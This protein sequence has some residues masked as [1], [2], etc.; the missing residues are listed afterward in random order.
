MEKWDSM[1]QFIQ[2]KDRHNKQC[3]SENYVC[4]K[5]KI[6]SWEVWQG[7]LGRC[8]GLVVSVPVSRSARPG[9]ESRPG[10]HCDDQFTQTELCQLAISHKL[11]V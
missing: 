4:F 3:G 10:A 1:E 5:L 9:F 7:G 11:L 8:G 2:Y 6:V